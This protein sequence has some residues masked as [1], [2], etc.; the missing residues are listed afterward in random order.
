MKLMAENFWSHQNWQKSKT[1]KE[2]LNSNYVDDSRDP[3][4]FLSGAVFNVYKHVPC[5]SPASTDAET[6][7]HWRME[8]SRATRPCIGRPSFRRSKLGVGLPSNE[9]LFRGGSATRLVLSK[10]LRFAVQFAAG[11]SWHTEKKERR[12]DGSNRNTR[13]SNCSSAKSK[14]LCF[15]N[16]ILTF[17]TKDICL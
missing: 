11:K 7:S 17:L 12:Q 16:F 6:N 15:L 2:K 10:K 14:Y 9:A 1:F 4:L 3:G 8:P 13:T 5:R